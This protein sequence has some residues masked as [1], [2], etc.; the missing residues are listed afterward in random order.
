MESLNP[1][2][3]HG[4]AI[5]PACPC[6]RSHHSV[7]AAT[8]YTPSNVPFVAGKTNIIQYVVRNGMT[9]R[10][11]TGQNTASGH[12]ELRVYLVGPHF[13]LFASRPQDYHLVILRG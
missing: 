1:A 12:G 13:A 3:G 8:C 9:F 10:V 5:L 2:A 4:R 11:L 7:G 6:A